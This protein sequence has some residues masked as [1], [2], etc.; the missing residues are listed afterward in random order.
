[1]NKAVA[2]GGTLTR[3]SLLDALKNEHRFTAQGIVGPTD[4]GGRVP[5]PCVVV[6]QV[7][8]GKWVR[9]FPSKPGTFNCDKKNLAVIKMDPAST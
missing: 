4:V 9:A 5:S 7:K 3:Q 2:N 8:G 6:A 1:V